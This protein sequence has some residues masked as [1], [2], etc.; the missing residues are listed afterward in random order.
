MDAITEAPHAA[1]EASDDR[2]F[3]VDTTFVLFF[4]AADIGPRLALGVESVLPAL[5]LLMF[6]GLPYFLP[7]DGEKPRFEPWLL[8]R[9][10][11]AGLGIL[12]GVVFQ[13]SLGV[14]L[15]DVFRFVPLTLLI[16]AGAVSAFVQLH[17][18]F[19]LRLAK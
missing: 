13:R 3:V 1:A 7:F 15:P 6:L 8:G 12:I 2:S 14:I 5:T 19:E 9:L 4:L 16:L 18:V 10:G 17:R 11:I